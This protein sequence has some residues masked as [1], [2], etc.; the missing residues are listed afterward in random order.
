MHIRLAALLIVVATLILSFNSQ[1][2]TVTEVDNQIALCRTEGGTEAIIAA[3]T[4]LLERGDQ[5]TAARQLYLSK[6]ARALHSR[7]SYERALEDADEALTLNPDDAAT[8]VWRAYTKNALGDIAGAKADFELARQ[9]GPN[10]K[11]VLFNIAKQMETWGE[12]VLALEGYEKVLEIDPGYW[13]VGSK[14][15][16]L[17][18]ENVSREEF[19]T[20]LANAE[21]R[22]RDHTWPHDAR[23][24]YELRHGYDSEKALK[25]VAAKARLEPEP[26]A[27][28][29]LLAL[30]HV[31]IG[32]EAKGIDYVEAYAAEMEKLDVTEPGF[33]GETYDKALSFIVL[34]QDRQW[35]YRS[36]AFAALGKES[37][38][39]AE[40]HR[41]LESGG[42]HAPK[43][44][45]D[46]IENAGVPV[47]KHA[48]AGSAEHI[49]QAI[50]D[51]IRHLEQKTGFSKL[52]P[53]PS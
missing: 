7:R 41:F 44:L 29:F 35:V 47:S 30:L 10:D 45:L 28:A 9:A 6:R 36:H 50:I 17:L 16:S 21:E 18:F 48:R 13:N 51:F 33:L 49:D 3:C 38:A 2:E 52:G 24:E 15:L 4:A 32:D 37:L 27:E 1:R 22:W 19:D 26:G 43:L 40:Y 25:A 34:G 23:F 12:D 46:V 8:L 53:K 31:K 14:Y 20:H 11:F 5:T 42:Q 39:R